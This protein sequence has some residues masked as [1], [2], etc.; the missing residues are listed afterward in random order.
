MTL[1]AVGQFCASSIIET[2]TIR[3][4]EL[5]KKASQQGAKML[6]LPE[7][8]DYISESKEQAGTLASTLKE[9]NFLQELRKTAQSEQIWVSTGVHEKCDDQER[10][11]NTHVVIDEHGDIVSTYRKI[12]LFDVDI[13]NGPRLMESDSTQAG[14]TLTPPLSSP[15]GML[16][17]QICYDLRFAELSIHQRR[18]GAHILA[19]PSAFTVKT[20]MAHWE[21]LLKARAIETQCYVM[22]AAQVGQHNAKRTS[23][24]HAMIIDPW[25][26]VLARCPDTS[27]PSLALANIDL[28]YLDSIRTDMPIMSHR[29]NDIYP[30]L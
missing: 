8:A 13:Q 15:I 2:N 4:C 28:E 7:A 5:I 27:S 23:Y 24:G 17:L 12:H 19:F 30:P 21:T 11:Y 10:V 26:T 22:A 3:C 29:R 18:Q 25:G 16:G 1:A 20:G 9:S 14:S 6:F